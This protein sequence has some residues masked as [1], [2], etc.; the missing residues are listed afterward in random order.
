MCIRDRFKHDSSEM[1]AYMK[2]TPPMDGVSEVLVPNDPETRE[3]EKRLANG[4]PI[5]ED[6]WNMIVATA[7]R[8]GVPVSA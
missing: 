7:Q 6:S 5:E 4:S 1:M 8:V 2:A 3:R